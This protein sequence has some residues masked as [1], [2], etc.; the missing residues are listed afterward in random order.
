MVRKQKDIKMKTTKA[1]KV[2]DKVKVCPF[3]RGRTQ[4]KSEEA[5]V[6][7]INNSEKYPLLIKYSTGYYGTYQLSGSVEIGSRQVI[8]LDN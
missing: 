3:L 7:S 6:T 2:G 1:F 4:P 5:I 8:F